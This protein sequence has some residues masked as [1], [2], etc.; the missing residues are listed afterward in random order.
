MDFC[1][2]ILKQTVVSI[3]KLYRTCVHVVARTGQA[4]LNSG[5]G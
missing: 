5:A 3:L 1:V 4:L 2:Q